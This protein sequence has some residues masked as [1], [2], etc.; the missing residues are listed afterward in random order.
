MVFVSF[1]NRFT[2][3]ICFSKSTTKQKAIIYEILYP[4]LGTDIVD[5]FCSVK[6]RSATRGGKGGKAP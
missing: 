4:S 2:Q 5:L 1:L 6:F 3:N